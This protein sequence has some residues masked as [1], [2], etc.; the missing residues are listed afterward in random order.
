L[1][2][3]IEETIKHIFVDCPYAKEIWGF[4]SAQG[5]DLSSVESLDAIW[6]IGKRGGTGRRNE[7]CFSGVRF[8]G[9]TLWNIWRERNGRIFRNSAHSSRSACFR[10]ED[11][12]AFWSGA[13][14]EMEEP[15]KTQIRLS[16]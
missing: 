11:D 2:A 12:F 1:C 9:A 15:R 4:F 6:E 7:G 3:N 5:E 14:V 16:R 13:R 8:I 10:I